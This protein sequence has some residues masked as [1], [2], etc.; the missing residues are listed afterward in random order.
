MVVEVGFDQCE[1]YLEGIDGGG[2]TI[3]SK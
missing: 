2:L 3:I 1:A